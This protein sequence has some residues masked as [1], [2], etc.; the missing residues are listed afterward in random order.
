MPVFPAPRQE[1]LA[2]PLRIAR[3]RR[4]NSGPQVQEAHRPH[5]I[6]IE[7]LILQTICFNFNLHRSLDPVDPTTLLPSAASSASNDALLAAA[8]LAAPPPTRD[9]FAYLL[10]LTQALPS[11]PLPLVREPSP[12]TTSDATASPAPSFSHE[13]VLKS[14]TFAA[15]LLLTDLHRTL[16]P[17]SYPPHTC[18]AAC[19][20][21]AGFVLVA[22]G[23]GAEGDSAAAG[24][25]DVWNEEMGRTWARTCESEKKDLDGA[26]CRFPR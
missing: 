22:A 2:T 8:T 3:G 9:A 11:L 4:S 14:L 5:L 15:F 18:A 12:S 13:S 6:G 16:V 21:L 17:L 20:W 10:R 23:A 26:R 7:R 19:V 25:E 1:L 24:E